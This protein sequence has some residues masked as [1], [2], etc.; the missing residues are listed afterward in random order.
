VAGAKPDTEP[1]LTVTVTV[2]GKFQ[3]HHDG[4]IARPGD[5]LTVPDD[6]LTARWVALGWVARD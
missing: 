5:T 2:S 6:E 1:V 4:V 3:V